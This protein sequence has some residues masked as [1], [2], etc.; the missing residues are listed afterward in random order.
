M[1]QT[2]KNPSVTPQ[3]IFSFKSFDDILNLKELG[4][5]PSGGRST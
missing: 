1:Q 4:G 2:G 3:L 5:E